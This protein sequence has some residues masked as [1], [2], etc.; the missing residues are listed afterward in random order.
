MEQFDLQNKYLEKI[1]GIDVP[2]LDIGLRNGITGYL[3]FINPDELGSNN[4]MKGIDSASRPFIV[5]KA[6]FE[7]SNGLKKKTFTTFFQRYS[8]DKFLWHCCGHYGKN[9]MDTSGGTNLEQV[10]LI[11]ELVVSNKYK[12]NKDLIQMQKLNFRDSVV[13][14]S[15]D[16]LTDDDFPIVI[17]LGHSI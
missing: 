7:F 2:I 15:W 17:N 14:I 4:I 13:S 11:Y 16:N 12:I 3:D 1:V 6:E 9:L 8:D 10:K 5:F